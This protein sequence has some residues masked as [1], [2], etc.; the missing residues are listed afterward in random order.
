MRRT[1]STVRSRVLPSAPQ[2]TET[3]RGASGSRRRSD[4]QR[5]ASMAGSVG[6]KNSKETM[7]GDA[8]AATAGARAVQGE[9][10][11]SAF[12][13]IATPVPVQTGT[14]MIDEER[15]LRV[16]DGPFRG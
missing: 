13:G 15:A 3:K 6:G 7:G 8:G 2:V 16:G 10:S 11:V 4:C 9:S 12:G 1:T 14:P 5:V